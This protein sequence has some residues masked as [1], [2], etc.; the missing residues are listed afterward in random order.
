MVGDTP[1]DCEAARKAG[2]ETI[3]L[4]TGGFGEAELTA[5][6]AIAVFKSPKDLCDRLAETPLG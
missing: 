1:W 2:L 6:G 4:L 3:C 5:A